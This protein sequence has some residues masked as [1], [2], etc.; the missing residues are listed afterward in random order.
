MNVLPIRT[1]L[2]RQGESLERFIFE[3]LA[4]PKEGSIIAVTSKILVPGL[5]NY[6]TMGKRQKQIVED[7]VAAAINDART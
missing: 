3:H 2:F 7:L 4:R 6:A 1:R 5:D